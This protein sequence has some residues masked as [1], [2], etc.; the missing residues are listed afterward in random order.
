MEETFKDKAN[1]NIIH[2]QGSLGSSAQIG[3]TEGL[4]AGV[5]R[6]AG[7]RILERDTGGFTQ[8]KG[9]E[10]ME[11]LLKLHNQIDVLYVE[12]D[13]MALG[14]IE[15]MTEAGRTFGVN[16]EITI[17]SFDATRAGLEA[18]LQG[19][20]NYNVECNPLHGPRVDAI[21]KMIENGQTPEK[22]MYVHEA[23][24]DAETITRQD[25]DARAY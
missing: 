16:G 2:L 23:S 12:N 4:M 1:L 25:I 8:V 20:I 19:K 18:T 6:N 5:D 21:I 11:R 15:A 3:R 9:K 22:L 7:W 13:D 17:I 14:A 10:V 24:F